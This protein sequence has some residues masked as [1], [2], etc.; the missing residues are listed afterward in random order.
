MIPDL[1]RIEWMPSPPL[2]PDDGPISLDLLRRMTLGDTALEREVLA[3]F[4]TQAVHLLERL[5]VLPED[6][7]S[8]AHTLKGSARAIGALDV[9]DAAEGLEVALRQGDPAD[10]L[11][12]L[13]TSVAQ[14][15]AAISDMLG[16]A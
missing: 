14:A 6:A 8:V 3:M 12:W 1:S 11:A 16:A 13:A 5:Q 15:R 7:A 9:A 10:A 2:V 4:S